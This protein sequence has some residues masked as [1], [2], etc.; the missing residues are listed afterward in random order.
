MYQPRSYNILFALC[1]A[2]A[3]TA[4][5]GVAGNGHRTSEHR[6]VGEFSKIEADGPF[7]VQVR[8]GDDRSLE[9]DIDSNLQAKLKTEVSDDTLHISSDSTVFDLVTGPHVLITVPHLV[10]ARV[11]GSGNLDAATFDEQEDVHLRDQG[12]GDL[13]FNGSTPSLTVEVTGSG[14]LWLNGTT[15]A[16]HYQLRGSGDLDA[17]DMVANGADIDLDGSG[18]LRATVNGTVNATQDGSGDVDLF[19]DVHTD[20]LEKH[21][22]GDLE[23]H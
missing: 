1:F 6:E 20:H 17:R 5:V 21:G 15:E 22:S 14:D 11:L 7:D 10:E 18:D 3:W 13:A 23:V 12:S 19:G 2:P 16:A 9:T 4:C 8:Q